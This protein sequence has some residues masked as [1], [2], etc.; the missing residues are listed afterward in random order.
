M[1]VEN[2]PEV[3]VGDEVEVV[4]RGKVTTRTYDYFVVDGEN[5]IAP[6]DEHVKSITVLTRPLPTTP[7]S[8]VRAQF[9]DDH[10]A[11]FLVLQD[12]GLWGDYSA[13]AV[14]ENG[15]DLIFD[16]GNPR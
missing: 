4:L 6:V 12:D 11:W 14:R 9:P 8:V 16:A 5:S 7:G 10:V 15:Y 2:P 3:R 1:T 13:E